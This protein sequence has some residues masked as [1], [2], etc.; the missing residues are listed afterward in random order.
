M[1]TTWADDDDFERDVPLTAA[2]I[3][4]LTSIE[5]TERGWAW[6]VEDGVASDG[7]SV[8]FATPTMDDDSRC[9]S[10]WCP[11]PRPIIAGVVHSD[12]TCPRCGAVA[13]VVT[14]THVV[15]DADIE[16]AV[17]AH[18]QRILRRQEELGT[19]GPV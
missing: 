19:L 12:G 16:D 7:V 3:G 13:W 5:A 1:T 17:R 14:T 4:T 10:C 11:V 6:A 9:P 2:T 18:R 15:T 8:A